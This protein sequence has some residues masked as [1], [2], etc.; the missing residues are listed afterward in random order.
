MKEVSSVCRICIAMCGVKVA[1]DD[2]GRIEG[3][4]P[5]RDHPLSQ[6]HFCSKGLHSTGTHNSPHR[7]LQTQKRQPDGSFAH[8]PLE[9]ALDEVAEK[10]I[11]IR[12]RHGPDALGIYVGGP[13]FY[14][15]PVYPFVGAFRQALGTN[16]FY[17]SVSID[18]PG[19]F[20]AIERLGHWLGG[21][22]TL[23]QSDV[24]MLVGTNPL[25][26]FQTTGLL[27]SD[28]VKLFKRAK[29]RGV[30]FIV[31]DP[32]RTET[33]RHAD[34]H[35]QP[36]PGEDTTVMAGLLKLI[37][38][39]GREDREFCVR[40]VREGHMDLLR[41][42]VAPFTLD[43]VERRTHAKAA[44]MI[45]AVEL[46]T[47]PGAKGAAFQ[48]TGMSMGAHSS[49]AV[50][51]M[52]VINVICGRYPREGE[53]VP[54]IVPW[55]PYTDLR[56]EVL[57]PQRSWEKKP[58]GRIR[59]V[60]SLIGEKFT[61][62]LA[63]E[64]MTPGPGQ[65]RALLNASGN[66]AA[67]VPDQR[68]IVAGL[69]DLDLL[70]T[71][72]PF[73]TNTSKLSHYVFAPKLQYERD[74]LPNAYPG[75]C[76]RP[77]SW[78]QFIP[79]VTS[80]PAGSETID[81]HY[82]FWAI[83]KR[84]GHQIQYLGV[85]IDMEKAPSTAE[86]LDHFTRGSIVPLDEIKRYPDGGKIFD[87]DRVVQPPNDDSG[88]F[89]PMPADVAKELADVFA[90]DWTTPKTCQG[91][92]RAFTHR[93]SVRRSRDLMNAQGL[94]IDEVRER[95]P[96]NPACLNPAD[97]QALG[98][99]DGDRVAIVSRRARVE[100]AVQGDET[101]LPGVVTLSH[102]WG[103]LPDDEGEDYERMGASS[104]L[105][106]DGEN[107][108]DSISSIALMTGVPVYIEVGGKKRTVASGE[109]ERV[110]A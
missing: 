43:Y 44:D 29:A 81:E 101:L 51:L 37:L 7:I 93:L 74:D 13:L 82:F 48:G 10:L 3:V 65:V 73:F 77:V 38:D 89:E 52:T 33:A 47:A 63:D 90:E 22:P 64:I 66:I 59:G 24:T 103:G 98:L 60:D 11:M 67:N 88:R 76:L 5:D 68:K 105:L 110:P 16:S 72:D 40:Y 107:D 35:V 20:V 87:I 83:A 14:N 46:F 39:R 78:G 79:A 8:I 30:K 12:D 100:V 18:T 62:N 106:L 45:K 55:L 49:L 21:R 71:L 50:H 42:A 17:T 109:R 15:A 26:S 58:P 4:R 108:L 56:A 84:L 28:P 94:Y 41:R 70:V 32:R 23:D 31:I 1:L 85:P 54:S 69:K 99:K 95:A 27:A 9:D 19:Q 36:L 34:V 6:G 97:M 91:T 80:P 86:L 61:C 102:S 96:Y 25:V 53:R 2:Q 104:N 57:P 92:G 75:L